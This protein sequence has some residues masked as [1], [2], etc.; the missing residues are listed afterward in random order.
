[1]ANYKVEG[2]KIIANVSLLNEKELTAVKNYMA[3]G[4][5]LEEYVKP[6]KQPN[7]KFKAATIQKWLD[8]N[9]TKAQ[10]EKY[11]EIYKSPVIDKKTGEKKL[12][13]DGTEKIK[14]HVATIA[15][16]KQEFPDY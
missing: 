15:W 11:W 9:G 8:D 1:M 3:L 7:E 6:K 12:K 5:T 16:F 2:K 4:Y 13:K 10:K 14:G